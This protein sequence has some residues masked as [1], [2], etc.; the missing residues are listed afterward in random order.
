MERW[1][2]PSLAQTNP[3]ASHGCPLRVVAHSL[4]ASKRRT[5]KLNADNHVHAALQTAVAA[6]DPTMVHPILKHNADVN[7]VSG[8]TDLRSGKGRYTP[9]QIASLGRRPSGGQ[10]AFAR[11]QCRCQSVS[12]HPRLD[13]A[14]S[15]SFQWALEQGHKSFRRLVHM[16]F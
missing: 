12:Q 16:L 15:G 14:S 10:E 7:T 1:V 11:N 9:L 2:Q 4:E 3:W 8:T 13:R 5:H 6:G